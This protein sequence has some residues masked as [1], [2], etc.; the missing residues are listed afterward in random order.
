MTYTIDT[1]VHEDLIDAVEDAVSY[2]CDE[3]MISGE[4]AWVIVE[5]LAE[6]KIAQLQ[7]VCD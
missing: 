5:S 3:Y 7:G 1:H 6:A 2:I 4:L